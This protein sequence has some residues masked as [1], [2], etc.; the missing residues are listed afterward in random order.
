[1]ISRLYQNCLQSE[2]QNMD[3]TA[4]RPI[5]VF[6]GECVLCS[7]WVRFLL[8]RDRAGRFRFAVTQSYTGRVLM[9]RAGVNPY[10]PSTFVLS[11][12][13]SITVQTEAIASVLGTLSFPW[14]LMGA[15]MMLAPSWVRNPVY[16]FVARNRYRIFGR[17]AYCYTPSPELASRFLS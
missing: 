4:Q 14:P 17:R 2:V 3:D 15:T 5:I 6:D 1:M 10:D 12:G 8:K 7:G 16:R 11:D 9:E 13:G